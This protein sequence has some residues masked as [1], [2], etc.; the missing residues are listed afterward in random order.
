MTPAACLVALCL[1]GCATRSPP[2][3]PP[4]PVPGCS[5]PPELSDD[6]R[7]ALRPVEVKGL[8]RRTCEW[9]P[10][11]KTKESEFGVFRICVHPKGFVYDATLEQS[12]GDERGDGLLLQ[13]IR[14]W[15]Y[16]PIERD[17]V[18]IAFCHKSKIKYSY[19]GAAE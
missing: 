17:G 8:M 6:E 18:A 3:P 14:R 2:S 9:Y 7:A 10:F 16:Q 5:Q 4:A 1:A 11:L 15:R 12:T 13:A 19:F